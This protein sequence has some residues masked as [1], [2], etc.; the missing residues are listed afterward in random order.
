M[1]KPKH[2][3]SFWTKYSKFA[4]TE[5][6]MYLIMVIGIALGILLLS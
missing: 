5:I 6:L 2:D 3:I 1:S 4:T